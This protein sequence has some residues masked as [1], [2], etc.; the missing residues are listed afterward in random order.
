MKEIL[1]LTG[2]EPNKDNKGGPSGLIWEIIERLKSRYSLTIKIKKISSNL[3]KLGLFKTSNADYTKYDL[4]FVYPFS[5]SFYVDKKFRYK[6]IVLGPDSPSL[7]FYR[8]YV[9][10]DTLKSRIK[11]FILFNWFLIREKQILREFKKFVVVG[12]ND[13]RWLKCTSKVKYL[14]HPILNSII[15]NNNKYINIDN[16]KTLVFSGDMSPKYTGNLIFDIY[17]QLNKKE[18]FNLPIIVVG[19]NNKWIFELFYKSKFTNLKYI[20][21]IDDYNE[22]CNPLHHIHVIPLLNGAGT[23]NRTLT[24]CAKGVPIIT[25]QIGFENIHYSKPLN[26]ILKFKTGDDFINKLNSLL[27]ITF[28]INETNRNKFILNVNTKFEIDLLEIIEENL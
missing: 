8:F 9:H 10:S 27:D 26:K 24:A 1:I 11:N 17:K 20:S 22:I 3:N 16:K 2:I 13:T 25:T 14:T 7:L 19:K 23:K 15:N 6:T 28:D 21:W 4:I 5:L 12:K 18:Y